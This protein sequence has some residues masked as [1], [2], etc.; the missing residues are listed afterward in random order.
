MRP[1][2][3]KTDSD[4]ASKGR[5]TAGGRLIEANEQSYSYFQ[6]IVRDK[7]RTG[8]K[9]R[10]PYNGQRWASTGIQ[11]T[12]GRETTG[13]FVTWGRGNNGKVESAGKKGLQRLEKGRKI[14]QNLKAPH[15][16]QE[17]LSPSNSHEFR[18]EGV[19]CVRYGSWSC[20]MEQSGIARPARTKLKFAS[21]CKSQ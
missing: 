6:A 4:S 12:Q 7:R 8:R 18:P 10:R 19:V 13:F 14:L 16:G 21:V 20:E 2:P 11:A 17:P 9:V 3:A 1:R 15:L 5:K